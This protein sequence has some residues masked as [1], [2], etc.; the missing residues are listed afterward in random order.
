M[1]PVAPATNPA[2]GVTGQYASRWPP[3]LAVVAAIVLFVT[4]P[5]KLSPGPRWVLPVLEAALLIPLLL[6][7][8]RRHV[9]ESTWAR[10]ASIVLI[11][12]INVADFVS[13][14]LLVREIVRGSHTSG[15]DLIFAAVQI[16]LT[17]VI[18]FGLWYWELDRGGPG[19]RAHSEHREPDFLFPQMVTPEAAPAGWAPS[20]VD[21][22]YVSLTNATAFSPTDTMPLTVWAKA[23]MGG[24][25]LASLVTV[26]VVAARAVNII[27][28]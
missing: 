17:N 9:G 8:P 15:H 4:L 22:L 18:V 26:A 13:L 5:E 14:G 23:L 21:Y 3:S 10:V 2:W 19:P 28:G 27:G 1:T 20:F 11:G 6:T 25:A 16:W 24:Q 7:A 12:L